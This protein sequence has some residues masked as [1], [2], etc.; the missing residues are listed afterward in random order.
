MWSFD[1]DLQAHTTDHTVVCSSKWYRPKISL[2]LMCIAFK[3]IYYCEVECQKRHSRDWK[4]NR[5]RFV[6]NW[7]RALNLKILL[8]KAFLGIGDARRLRRIEEVWFLFSCL[9]LAIYM[10]S[11]YSVYAIC[12]NRETSKVKPSRKEEGWNIIW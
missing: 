11:I 4:V 2:Q 5:T 9:F 7:I 10:Y 12:N 6:T 3:Y 8:L 1:F